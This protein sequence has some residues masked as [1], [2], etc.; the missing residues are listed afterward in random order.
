VTALDSTGLLLQGAT[1][2]I[3]ALHTYPAHSPYLTGMWLYPS[4]P[5]PDPD[6]A[7]HL[8]FA[9]AGRQEVDVA[10]YADHPAIPETTTLLATWNAL[11]ADAWL[12]HLAP[13]LAAHPW[14]RH[15]HRP[16]EHRADLFARLVLAYLLSG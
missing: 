10:L 13:A 3:S 12:D 14:I 9:P 6:C 2:R 11:P 7:L 4:S 8:S 5:P 1:Y 15:H 16:R